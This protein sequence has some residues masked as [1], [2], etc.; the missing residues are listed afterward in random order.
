MKIQKAMALHRDVQE[1]LFFKASEIAA[2]ADV[3]L[4]VH[5]KTGRS[6]VYVSQGR[7]DYYAVL[8]DPNA[9]QIEF[10]HGAYMRVNEASGRMEF[11]GASKP[12][13]ILSRASGLRAGGV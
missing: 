8:D 13:Y 12:L 3:L 11:I 2:K 7:V 1:T 9:M 10:G 6:Q 5:H 4:S